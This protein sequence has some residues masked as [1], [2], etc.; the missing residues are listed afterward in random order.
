MAGGM[1][2]SGFF[3][4]SITNQPNNL[5]DS[6]LLKTVIFC[7][8]KFRYFNVFHQKDRPLRVL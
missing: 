2:K 6:S 3:K 1:N 7:E 4:Q 5:A 8:A